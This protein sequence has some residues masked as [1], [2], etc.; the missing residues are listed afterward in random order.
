MVNP[1]AYAATATKH[2]RIH[3]VKTKP[4]RLI[5]DERGWLLEILRSDEG[6][7]RRWLDHRQPTRPEANWWLYLLLLIDERWKHRPAE[8]PAHEEEE[9]R[10]AQLTFQLIDVTPQRRLGQAAQL[11][12][13]REAAGLQ[14]GME[15]LQQ[16]PV[17]ARAHRR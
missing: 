6:E 16:V 11:G 17:V 1:T 4:L 13:G 15:A 5:P 9:E 10:R 3:G 12:R 14:D 8:R 2:P 7:R